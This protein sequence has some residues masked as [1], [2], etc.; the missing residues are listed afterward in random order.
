MIVAFITLY[1]YIH[2]K[3]SQQFRIWHFEFAAIAT[4]IASL[5]NSLYADIFVYKHMYGHCSAYFR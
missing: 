4:S 5:N 2:A 3:H 1:N